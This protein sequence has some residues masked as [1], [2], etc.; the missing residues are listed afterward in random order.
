MIS[1]EGIVNVCKR[2]K[3]SHK[4]Y[5]RHNST[6][7]F[8]KKWFCGI[9]ISDLASRM[10]MGIHRNMYNDQPD[11]SIETIKTPKKDVKKFLKKYNLALG[12]ISKSNLF[13][14]PS[15]LMGNYSV[16]HKRGIHNRLPRLGNLSNDIVVDSNTRTGGPEY[17]LRITLAA[18]ANGPTLSS[19]S[20]DAFM[21]LRPE[22]QHL[23]KSIK[24]LWWM[25]KKKLNLD[26]YKKTFSENGTMELDKS[27]SKSQLCLGRLHAIKDKSCKTRIIAIIDTFSQIALRPFHR[28]LDHTMKRI[29]ND[30]YDNHHRGVE[31][32]MKLNKDMWSFDVTSATDTIPVDLGIWVLK[33]V[34]G[35]YNYADFNRWHSSRT[36]KA[37]ER[38]LVEREFRIGNSCEYVKYSCG[39]PMGAYCSFPLLGL[40]Q[41]LLVHLAG[42]LVYNKVK[43]L[44]YAVVG[45]DIVIADE[46]VAKQYLT[47]CEEVGIPINLSKTITGFK[48]FEFCSRIVVNGQMRSTPSLKGL[49]ESIQTKDPY[50]FLKLC[51]EYFVEIPHYATL[52]HFFKARSLR[53]TMALTGVE[54]PYAPKVVLIPDDIKSHAERTLMTEKYISK[55]NK[56]LKVTTDDPFLS[57]LNYGRD[58][59]SILQRNLKKMRK[60]GLPLWTAIHKVNANTFYLGYIETYLNRNKLRKNRCKYDKDSESRSE[61]IRRCAMA[62]RNLW[63]VINSS[64][65]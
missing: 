15:V 51:K 54:I 45:D 30:F 56:K 57:R 23:Y 8:S 46:N 64:Y 19:Q 60:S 10:L 7:W 33:H 26:Y 55:F 35:Q 5:L 38:L 6:L 31:Y 59:S 3:M 41:H 4:N 40:T 14:F 21:L 11:Y 43:F 47:L 17:P 22:N 53:N 25:S 36:V 9:G 49:Y 62:N 34:L 28:M 18:S 1:R 13:K 39:Q 32:L 63:K 61:M 2:L 29:R 65:L 27:L 24:M 50:P 44:D 52:C 48:T 58:V 37:I 20:K 12:I 42:V 16:I